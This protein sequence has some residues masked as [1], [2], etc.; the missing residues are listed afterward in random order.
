MIPGLSDLDSAAVLALFNLHQTVNLSDCGFA[1][2]LRRGI[3]H[4]LEIGVTLAPIPA[5]SSSDHATSGAESAGGLLSL[6]D[7]AIDQSPQD[8]CG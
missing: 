3:C 1:E 6:S 7:S 2:A 5:G 4:R 8:L